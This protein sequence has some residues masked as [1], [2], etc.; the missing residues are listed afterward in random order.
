[1]VLL[2]TCGSGTADSAFKVAG[3]PGSTFCVGFVSAAF[4]GTLI[5][6]IA[7]APLWRGV[8]RL[9]ECCTSERAMAFD[10]AGVASDCAPVT[11]GAWGNC[12]AFLMT[13]RA[14]EREE[15][16]VFGY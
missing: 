14:K 16:P 5:G 11:A 13:K 10:F 4:S 6:S 8:T 9:S 2:L 7:S 1:M 12:N 3:R 15:S